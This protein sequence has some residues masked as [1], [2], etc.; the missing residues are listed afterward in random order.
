[1]ST[2]HAE[3]VFEPFFTTKEVGKGTGLGLSTSS[4]IV[5]SHGGFIS[6]YSEIGKGTVFKVY[7][8][9]DTGPA[10]ESRA[11]EVDVM[12]RGRGEKILIVDDEASILNIT[13]QMF[14]AGL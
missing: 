8:P 9:A 7:L 2:E 4:G 11:P 6:V 13:Q 12:P 14:R 3:H 1:M 10:V 5:G